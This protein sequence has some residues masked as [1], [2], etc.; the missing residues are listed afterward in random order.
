MG[1]KQQ[2]VNDINIF[3]RN[4]RHIKVRLI[5]L[6][7]LSFFLMTANALSI[8]AEELPKT[9]ETAETAETEE[10]E[11]LPEESETDPESETEE[12]PEPSAEPEEKAEEEAVPEAEALQ[13]EEIIEPAEAEESLAEE[14]GLN[15][16]EKAE[17]TILFY[18]CGSDLES[19]Q[20]MASNNLRQIIQTEFS[21]E[22]K[23]RM[24]VFAGGSSE[25]HLEPSC[26]YGV[27]S[28]DVKHNQIF[29]AYGKDYPDENKRGKLVHLRSGIT[30]E[31]GSDPLPI[32]KESA[33]DP[34]TLKAFINYGYRT[35]P[36]KR[37]DLILWDH[38]SGPKGGF[39]IDDFTDN[40]EMK[41]EQIRDALGD[42]DVIRNQKTFDFVNF[43]TCLMGSAEVLLCFAD[44]MDYYISSPE[45]I[46]SLGQNYEWLNDLGRAPAMDTYQLGKKIVDYFISFY[47]PDMEKLEK[48]KAT[49]AVFD[50]KKIL[51]SQFTECLIEL[52]E[53]L[54]SEL[55]QKQSGEYLFYDELLTAANSIQY[56]EK[57]YRDLG[58][59]AAMIG[60]AQKEVSAVNASSAE[61]STEN[62]YTRVVLPLITILSD[63]SLIYARGTKSVRTDN[64]F[65]LDGQGQLNYDELPTSGLYVFFPDSKSPG[66]ILEYAKH[67]QKTAEQLPD[68]DS[69][70]EF[71][72]SYIQT[73]SDLTLLEQCGYA[74]SSLSFQ[75]VP[76]SDIDYERVRK[77]W[78]ENE[79]WSEVIEKIFEFRNEK[80]AE[81][82]PWLEELITQQKKEVL[83]VSNLESWNVRDREGTG[84]QIHISDVRKRVIELTDIQVGARIAAA[85]KYFNE[86][87]EIEKAARNAGI[88]EIIQIGTKEGTRDFMFVQGEMSEERLREY[89][90][91]LNMPE[92][93]WNIEG[94]P[95]KWYALQDEDGGLHAAAIVPNEDRVFEVTAAYTEEDRLKRVHLLFSEEDGTLREIRFMLENGYT[96]LKPEDLKNELVLTTARDFQLFGLNYYVFPISET[97]FRLNSANASSLRLIYTDAANI[98]DIRREDETPGFTL[99]ASIR[100][101]YGYE[102][103]VSEQV[104]EKPKGTRTSVSLAELVPVVYNGKTQGPIVKFKDRILREGIDYLLQKTEGEVTADVGKYNVSL[105]GIGEYASTILTEFE[106]IPEE[107]RNTSISGVKDQWYTGKEIRPLPVVKL[108][109]TVLEE[110][111]DYLLSYHDNINVGTAVIVIEGIGNLKDK[112]VITFRIREKKSGPDDPKESSSAD[113]SGSETRTVS[114][115]YYIPDTACRN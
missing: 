26:L 83:A 62:R 77:H 81:T 106:I 27:S 34:G 93:D 40:S 15:P 114:Q 56:G 11:S 92:D 86:H 91:W 53:V 113:I 36:A 99:K 80:E 97:T 20:Q 21:A 85:V 58:N 96:S 90:E 41:I 32:E 89:I 76:K 98:H 8:R 87:D 49:L 48:Q 19:V 50:V 112:A 47:Q 22:G 101:I 109:D 107:M 71:L 111:K 115:N 7:F 37:Y 104:V 5:I 38:G 10:K 25:W 68:T 59:I 51:A 3:M 39:A 24:L 33:S 61:I 60:V 72:L 14:A 2:E 16:E 6:C 35:A 75:G 42:N 23:V 102:Y 52:N 100:D 63:P 69:R 95:E 84:Y 54:H 78:V 67:V 94:F 65:R 28:I 105:K 55:R 43:D 45:I 108:G 110:G 30:N 64:V 57:E 66:A 12:L 82:R 17:R 18:I 29:E 9:E 103:N 44:Y 74:V 46:P 13:E 31:E 79:N 4:L 73:L 88:T 70:K 1:L